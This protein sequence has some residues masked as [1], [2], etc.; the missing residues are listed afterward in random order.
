MLAGLNVLVFELTARRTLAQLGCGRRRRR[1]SREAVATLSL[2]IWVGVIVAGR[3]IGFTATR[4]V[5]D[6][7][8]TRDTN[9]EDLLGLPAAGDAAP[10]AG[11]GS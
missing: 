10:P 3:M 5:A 9:F 8:D 4:P 2:V 1:R 11:E 6:R 7:A